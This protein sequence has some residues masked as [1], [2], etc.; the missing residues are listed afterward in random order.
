[1]INGEI[2]CHR[3]TL[4]TLITIAVVVALTLALAFA[5]LVVPALIVPI[6]TLG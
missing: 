5:A 1:M 2:L 4:N 6:V 3:A